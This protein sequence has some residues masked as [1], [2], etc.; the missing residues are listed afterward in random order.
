MIIQVTRFKRTNNSTI[1]SATIDGVFQCYFLEDK[2]RG[3]T[4]DMT[5]EKIQELKIKG[6]TAIPAGTYQV[7]ITWSN[8][9]K[10]NLPLVKNVPGF[11]GIRIHPGNTA[12]D[13]KGCLLPG[14]EAQED[15]VLNSRVAFAMLFSKIETVIAKETVIINVE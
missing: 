14:T 1:S 7:V 3:L 13:T 12:V 8:R 15:I 10:R 5:L 4:Q 11:D 6:K 9:F 2:D